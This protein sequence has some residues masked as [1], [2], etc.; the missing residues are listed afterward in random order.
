MLIYLSAGMM[1]DVIFVSILE[2][3][4][5]AWCYP[6]LVFAELIA[7]ENF[8]ANLILR[9]ESGICHFPPVI[10]HIRPGNLI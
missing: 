8:S 1:N 3:G 9:L 5:V 10:V 4:I 2:N 7:A 6:A